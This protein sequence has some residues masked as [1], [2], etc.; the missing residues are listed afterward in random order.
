M[1]IERQI[2]VYE[3]F[4]ESTLKSDLN[5]IKESLEKKADS[6]NQW[7]DVKNIV[8]HWRRINKMNC[9]TNVQFEIGCG[10]HSFGEVTDCEKMYIDVGL[11]VLLEMDYDEADKYADIRLKL[12][13]K[14]IEH[15]QKLAVK[16]K[17]HIKMV[18]L[19]I[20]HLQY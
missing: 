18:L 12:I 9:D 2:K 5:N 15:L 20:H 1:D 14:E 11:G 6:F 8:K 4:I 10:I 19:T 17:V 3:D 13:S 7:Q 16:V